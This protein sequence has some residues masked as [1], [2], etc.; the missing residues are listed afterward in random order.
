MPKCELRIVKQAGHIPMLGICER[1]NAQ[2]KAAPEATIDADAALASISDQFDAH[3]CKPIDSSQDAL[4]IVR[5]STEG[6]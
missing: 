2:F 3:T 4:R 1:C 5:E 6:K